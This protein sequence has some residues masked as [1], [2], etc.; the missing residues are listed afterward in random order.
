MLAV[1]TYLQSHTLEELSEEFGIKLT[2]HEHLPLVILNYNQIDS[3]KTHP[4]VRECRGLVLD[5]GTHKVVAKGFD[6]F[7][8]WGEVADEMDWFDFSDFQAQAKEDGSM[9][10]FY[11]Y[12]GLWR[13]NTR[14]T[15]AADPM[16]FQD[17]TWESAIHGALGIG[18]PDEVPVGISPEATLVCEFCSPWNKIVRRYEK[19]VVYL[20]SAFDNQSLVEYPSSLCDQLAPQLGMKRPETYDFSSIED[21]QEFLQKQ[22]ETDSTYE[23]V[24]IRDKDGRRWKIKSATYLAWHKMRGENDDLWNPKHLLPFVLAG[25][26]DEL[27]TYF[28][29]VKPTYHALKCA[30]QALYIEMLELWVVHRDIE[31]QKAF[32]LKVKDSPM[33]AILFHVRKLHGKWQSVQDIRYEWRDAGRLILKR[34]GD[35]WR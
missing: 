32:A 24:V 5:S 16:P 8:N 28:P 6:R 27:L 31:D 19:P 2:R 33:A 4:V 26:E 7:F 25:E 13:V 34:L 14:G 11:C 20:L 9:C 22:E 15:F 18:W 1:Q 3:P 17:F 10:L 12:D 35:D 23:G 29:E 21:V 30:V